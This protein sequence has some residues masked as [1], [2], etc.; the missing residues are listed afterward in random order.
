MVANFPTIIR[1]LEPKLESKIVTSEVF[2]VAF[3]DFF[4]KIVQASPLPLLTCQLP[5]SF[6]A[7]ATFF[8]F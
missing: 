8:P 1:A 6:F 3:G 2:R 5:Y 4:W 7:N